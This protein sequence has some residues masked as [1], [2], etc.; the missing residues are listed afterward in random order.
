MKLT[1]IILEI[2]YKS[3]EAM[4]QVTYGDEGAEGYDDALRALPGVTT[5]TK[6]NSDAVA[7]KT[8]YKVKLITQKTPEEAFEAFK[9]NAISKY[10]NVVS[11]EVGANTIEE[12]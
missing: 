11:V 1:D 8:T 12:K 7:G 6:A 4:V 5:V 9:N 10:T 2:E 3:Y